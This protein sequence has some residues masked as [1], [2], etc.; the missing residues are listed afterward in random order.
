[1]PRRRLVARLDESIQGQVTLITAGPGSG[2][3]LLV[4][5]WSETGQ[6][7]GPVAWLSLD[8]YDN[9]PAAFW[10]YLLGALRGTGA[11]PDYSTLAHIRPGRRVD[12]TFVRRIGRAVAGLPHPI[13]L[14][15]EDSIARA[16]AT[17]PGIAS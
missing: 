10:S 5:E 17:R 8:G 13:V 11:V 7:P 14:V 2:K 16:R 15:L 9:N 4:A 6:V 1:V 12:E 3:T